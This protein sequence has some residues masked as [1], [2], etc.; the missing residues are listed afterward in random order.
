VTRAALALLAA[1][2][3]FAAPAAGSPRLVAPAPRGAPPPPA[4]ASPAE[5]VRAA[6]EGIRGYRERAAAP[7][8]RDEERD[9][10]ADLAWSLCDGVLGDPAVRDEGLRTPA[11][12]RQWA[13]L[14]LDDGE[15]DE[16]LERLE[17]LRSLA[18]VDPET[19]YLLGLTLARLGRSP[20]AAAAFRRALELHVDGEAEVRARLASALADGGD[21]QAAL[22][23]A[24]RAVAADPE[25]YYARFVRGRIRGELGRADA[26][27]DLLAAARLYADDAELW[28]AIARERERRG[29]AAGEL[30]A[31]REVLRL[32]PSDALA[33]RTVERLAP[34][35]TAPAGA[36]GGRAA[37]P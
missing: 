22:A 35:A 17:R 20:A 36:R 13:L 14:L 21:R 16:A 23:E 3:L 18:P 4:A 32:D 2:T 12:L 7:G 27:A 11:F 33:A 5:Q 30:A 25:E 28:E 26:L 9:E 1:A 19:H 29:D 31:W 8:L 24:E 6:V 15:E 37:E 34:P 10:L